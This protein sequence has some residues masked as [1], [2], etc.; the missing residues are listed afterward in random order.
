MLIIY[1]HERCG[2]CKKAKALAD[3]YNLEYEYRDTDNM[4]N[5]N[6]LKTDFPNVKSVPQI[7]WNEKHVGGYEDFAA[8][9]ENTIGGFGDQAF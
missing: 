2:W 8:E 6:T 7:W 4:E 5:L 1:G 9:I 3:Q